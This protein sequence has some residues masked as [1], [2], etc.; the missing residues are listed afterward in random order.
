M[1]LSEYV[2]WNWPGLVLVG[3]VVVG[4]PAVLIGRRGR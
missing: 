1:T 3:S 4:V 2:Y